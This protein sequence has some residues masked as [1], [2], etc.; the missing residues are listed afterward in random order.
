[1]E[2]RSYGA[3]RVPYGQKGGMGVVFD[4]K[5]RP[6]VAV[7]MSSSGAVQLSDGG[8]V[9]RYE[10][11]LERPWDEV[12]SEVCARV[13]EGDSLRAV[14]RDWGLPVARFMTWVASDDERRGMYEG[15]LRLRADELVHE[16]LGVAD[17]N[18]VEMCDGRL[19]DGSMAQVPVA[20]D[21]QRDSLRVKTRLAAAGLW[22]RKRFGRGDGGGV[23]LKVVVQRFQESSVDQTTDGTSITV[24]AGE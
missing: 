7:L 22:D 15:A 17:N 12:M 19:K 13:V 1:M 2:P 9:E 24:E 14:A 23:G 8:P 10:R 21:P 3:S 20:A 6:R 18:T 11:L 5:L 16:S 4:G